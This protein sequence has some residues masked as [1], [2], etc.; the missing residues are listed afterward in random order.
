MDLLSL[1]PRQVDLWFVLLDKVASPSLLN[2]YRTLLSADELARVER[3]RADRA[4]LEYLTGRALTRTVL[5]QYAAVAPQDWAFSYNPHGKPSVAASGGRR[6]EFNLSHTE[7]VLVLAV[8]SG[9]EIGVDVESR[10]RR[11]NALGLAQRFFAASEA[12]VLETLPPDQLYERFFDFWTLKE[13]FIKARGTGLTMP[14][15][16]FAFTLSPDQ[17][18]RIAFFGV[19]D[20]QSGEWQFAQLQLLPNH[21]I[22]LAVRLPESERLTLRTWETVPLAWQTEGTW[23]AENP[24]HRWILTAAGEL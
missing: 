18:P 10:S 3:Y 5:S 19:D 14:L 21:Q 22:A 24:T 6:L 9:M 11:A 8:A 20:E 2:A 4:R 15:D 1:Q 7:G 16:R 17:P 12:A 23:L 13:S